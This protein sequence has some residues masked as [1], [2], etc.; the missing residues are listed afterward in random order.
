[1]QRLRVT[2]RGLQVQDEGD[3]YTF[4]TSPRGVSL[5][6]KESA[7][8]YGDKP[9]RTLRLVGR[10]NIDDFAHWLERIKPDPEEEPAEQL[11]THWSEYTVNAFQNVAMIASKHKEMSVDMELLSLLI[12]QLGALL[13]IDDKSRKTN[14]ETTVFGYP[15]DVPAGLTPIVF[16]SQTHSELVVSYDDAF[17]WDTISYAQANQLGVWMKAGL[18]GLKSKSTW[19]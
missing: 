5:Y 3:I 11:P 9:S 2:S 13:A 18:A 14:L 16:V 1:M 6:I 7:L 15:L 12:Q 17:H 19:S 10:D 8:H 4:S